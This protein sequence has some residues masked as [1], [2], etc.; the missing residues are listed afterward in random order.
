MTTTDTRGPGDTRAEPAP[1]RRGRKVI[2]IG[3]VVVLAAAGGVAAGWP[4]IERIWAPAPAAARSYSGGVTGT[5]T[6]SRKD[7]TAREQVDGTIGYSGSYEVIAKAHGTL[8]WVPDVGKVIKQ[9][10]TA[11]RVDGAKVVLLYGG[12]PAYRNLSEGDEGP[13]VK[14]LNH[15]LVDLD[16]ASSSEIDPSSDYYGAATADAVERLQ[17]DLG[18]TEDGVLHLGQAVFLPTAMRVTDVP[19][20]AGATANGPVIKGTSTTRE[21]TVN[22]DASQQTQVRKGDEVS[23]TLPGG[24]TTD[25]KVSK[26]GTVASSAPSSSD[27][28]STPPPTVEID[29]APTHPSRTG[30]VDQGP[31]QVEIITD[32]V[33]DA[34]VVPVTALLATTGGGY[35]VEVI[36]PDGRHRLVP[37]S[38]GTFDDSA[39][40]V[41]VTGSGLAAGQKI[42]VAAS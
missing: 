1:R 23:I 25:G 31:V 3:T 34:L 9:G 29:I 30:H 24:D 19:G 14:E 33:K 16:Y 2:I 37:V 38:T 4:R 39:G 6:V 26:V 11:Y 12:T 32:R 18:V 17:D 10:G 22:L 27:T 42:V 28:G 40:I 8:T 7:L 41:Q 21:V 20:V 36:D 35:A 5:A 15:A 13:D